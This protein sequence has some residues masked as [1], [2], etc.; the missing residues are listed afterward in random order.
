MAMVVMFL[1]TLALRGT[2]P[3]F[4][5][6]IQRLLGFGPLVAAWSQM[7]PNLVYGAAVLLVGRLSDRLPTYVLVMTGLL[8]Y[9][10]VFVSY[11]GINEVTTLNMLMTFL[12]IRFI[13]EA[14]I[15]SPNNLSIHHALTQIL[16]H[17]SNY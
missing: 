4:A 2:G 7:P 1:T 16:L 11:M 15:V 13:A 14:F 6:L 17:M 12:I 5:V 9:G 10:A 3:M 8:M